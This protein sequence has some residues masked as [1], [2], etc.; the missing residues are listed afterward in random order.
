MW[1]PGGW[2]GISGTSSGRR[3]SATPLP[4]VAMFEKVMARQASQFPTMSAMLDTGFLANFI[5][6]FGGVVNRIQFD[7]YHLYPV[8][9]HLLLTVNNIKTIGTGKGDMEDILFR[10]VYLEIRNKKVLL[11]AALLH[12][13]GK[14]EPSE[15]HS[16][17]GAD[18]ARAILT[19]KGMPQSDVDTVVFLVREHLLLFE[20]AT[21]RDINDEETAIFV[22][23]RV[24]KTDRLKKL[25]LLS[26]ADAMATG[27]KAW[28]DWTASLL[29]GLFLK[30]LN[31]LEEGELV[32][33]KAT[34]TIEH[35]K[36]RVLSTALSTEETKARKQILSVMS[37]RLSG[38]S[39]NPRE[40]TPA[41]SPSAER[42]GP[43]FFPR[44]P[45]SFHAEQHQHP[46]CT[47]FT[48]R[49]NIALDVFEVTPPPDPIFEDERWERARR[50]LEDALATDWT[51][52]RN[53]PV[54]KTMPHR[55]GPTR[56]N[57]PRK[58][59]WTMIPPAFYHC[60]SSDL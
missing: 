39:K 7:Q 23:R 17:R 51:W 14:A 48:W 1:R 34:R 24:K 5:P 33:R 16:G 55:S 43:A 12:D 54:K 38:A 15:G 44:L 50:N 13:I 22:A 35:K 45:A 46:R 20:T 30:A 42:T 19:E 56:L 37:P 27:P 53:W 21:R 57:G 28:N 26:V 9:R 32:S 8:A 41:P 29:R 49:N 60:R 52:E 40:R 31:I 3:N 2:S 47:D 59:W 10:T 6:N 11:W 36:D 25:Y 58:S 4:V 18:M